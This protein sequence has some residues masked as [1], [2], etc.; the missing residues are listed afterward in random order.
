MVSHLYSNQSA[1]RRKPLLGLP[2]KASCPMQTA[3]RSRP[4]RGGDVMWEPCRIWT[5]DEERGLMWP[6]EFQAVL[7]TGGGAGPM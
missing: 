5:V 4:Q 3:C 2:P 6:D 7:Q 1:S